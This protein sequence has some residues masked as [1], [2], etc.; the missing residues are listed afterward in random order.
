MH[1]KYNSKWNTDRIVKLLL[2]FYFCLDHLNG[3]PISLEVGSGINLSTDVTWKPE[4]SKLAKDLRMM[5][6]KTGGVKYISILNALGAT[7][8]GLT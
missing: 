1:W 2:F 3:L 5:K 8:T 7:K 6:L 4:A